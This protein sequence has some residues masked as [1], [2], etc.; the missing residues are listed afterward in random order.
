MPIHWKSLF[1]QPALA[2]SEPEPAPDKPTP[3]KL[4]KAGTP[5]RVLSADGQGKPLLG[6]SHAIGHLDDYEPQAPALDPAAVEAYKQIVQMEMPSLRETF[7]QALT[8]PADCM[9]PPAHWARVLDMEKQ[10]TRH[11]EQV[12]L[13]TRQELETKELLLADALAQ[14][15]TL[16]R[17]LTTTRAQLAAAKTKAARKAS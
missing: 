2:P 14:Q 11:M 4:W 17:L 10:R 7:K 1:G 9:I 6:V 15:S 8:H 5:V 16:L 12:Y 13:R 3:F